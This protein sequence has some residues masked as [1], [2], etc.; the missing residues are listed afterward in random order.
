MSFAIFFAVAR[1][2]KQNR[3]G[4]FTR[5]HLFSVVLKPLKDESPSMLII[6]SV[7]SVVKSL[8]RSCCGEPPTPPSPPH[9]ED[10][11]DFL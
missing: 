10:D 2:P 7:L 3:S 5:F 8:R 6:C 9:L 11:D 4:S 1:A